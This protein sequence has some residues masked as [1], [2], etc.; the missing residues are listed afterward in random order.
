M[1]KEYNMAEKGDIVMFN[2]VKRRKDLT[3]EQFRDYWVNHHN[4]IEKEIVNAGRRKKIYARFLIGV[5]VGGPGVPKGQIDPVKDP[6]WDA[7]WELHFDSIE[8]LKASLIPEVVQ[9]L[10]ADEKNFVEPGGRVTYVAQEYLMAE[11]TKPMP[12]K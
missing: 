9:K 10:N 8:D 4:L 1:I 7:V 12:P 3:P 6:Q 11:R 2:F 5:L